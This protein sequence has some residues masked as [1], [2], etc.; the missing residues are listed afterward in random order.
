MGRVGYSEAT[1]AAT[2]ALDNIVVEAYNKSIKHIWGGGMAVDIERR[3]DK[4]SP[5][6]E[7]EKRRTPHLDRLDS[8]DTDGD[9][10]QFKNRQFKSVPDPLLLS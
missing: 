10:E 4:P 7:M 9:G 1:A 3:Y 6:E 5:V 8:D 2:T